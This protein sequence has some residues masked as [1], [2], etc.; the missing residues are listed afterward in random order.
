LSRAW[1]RLA[2]EDTCGKYSQRSGSLQNV[3]TFT[4]G[5][6][7]MVLQRTSFQLGIS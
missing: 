4:P 5:A 3:A 1:E 2:L 7:F 6:I